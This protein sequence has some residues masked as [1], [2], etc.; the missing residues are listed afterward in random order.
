M[1]FLSSCLTSCHVGLLKTIFASLRLPYTSVILCIG[2]LSGLVFHLISDDQTF[3]T[4]T[5]SS[6]DFLLAI[7][8]P[9]LIFESAYRIEYHSLIKSLYSILVLSLL[10]YL[11][12]LLV[13][14]IFNR[15]AF[16]FEQWTVL[17][18][19]VLSVIISLSKPVLINHQTGQQAFGRD[20]RWILS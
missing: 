9:A 3:V 20:P 8:L 2:L 1:L 6:P 5:K 18:S 17:Q 11:L 19:L 10:G 14:T 13:L 12:S 15:Y 16:A 7:F 4:L